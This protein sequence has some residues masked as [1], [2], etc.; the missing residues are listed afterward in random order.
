[1]KYLSAIF[2]LLVGC[3]TVEPDGSKS[4][5]VD[6]AAIDEW[7]SGEPPSRIKITITK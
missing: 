1:M 6:P 7:L 2:L 5:T 4:V 3:V